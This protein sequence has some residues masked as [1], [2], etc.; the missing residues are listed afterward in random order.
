MIVRVKGTDGVYR[1]ERLC[2]VL[3]RLAEKRA[4]NNRADP[5]MDML[6]AEFENVGVDSGYDADSGTDWLVADVGAV[7]IDVG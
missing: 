7:K 3:N 4:A 2:D 5:G 6:A 1:R